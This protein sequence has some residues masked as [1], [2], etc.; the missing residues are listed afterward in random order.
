MVQSNIS[1]GTIVGLVFLSLIDMPIVVVILLLLYLVGYHI[2]ESLDAPLRNITQTIGNSMRKAA[3]YFKRKSDNQNECDA[4]KSKTSIRNCI[5]SYTMMP[6]KYCKIAFGNAT[7]WLK[8]RFIWHRSSNIQSRTHM[9][10]KKKGC[11]N[12]QLVLVIVS[13]QFP[14]YLRIRKVGLAT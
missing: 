3:S 11:T 4:S 9:V 2:I 14:P 10:S 6:A 13:S 1:K 7:S 12:R 8:P 5:A